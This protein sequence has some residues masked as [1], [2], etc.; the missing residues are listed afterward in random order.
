[1]KFNFKIQQYQTDAVDSVVNC[2]K[3]QPY[4]D[5][6]SYRRDIGNKREM[7]N[8]SQMS[9]VN[10]YDQETLD[11]TDDFDESGFKN[12]NMLI[13]SDMVL[14]NIK[15]VQQNNNVM[16]SDSLV[17][18]MGACSLDVEMETGE[19]GIFVTGERN[20]GFIRVSEALS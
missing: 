16:V 15:E 12:E 19:R 1:M 7:Q 4:I 14:S 8:Y 6:V 3:G 9:F 10:N 18:S 11:F 5:N 2:F 20:L 17:D 13:S